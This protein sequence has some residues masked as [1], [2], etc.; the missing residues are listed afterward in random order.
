MRTVPAGWGVDSAAVGSAVGP[1]VAAGVGGSD[2]A[3]LAL[4]PGVG[5]GTAGAVAPA[6]LHPARAAAISAAMMRGNAT[7]RRAGPVIAPAG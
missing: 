3:P 5:G 1:G 2:V 7:R 4:A 6:P